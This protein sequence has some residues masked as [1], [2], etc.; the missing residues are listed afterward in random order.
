M[1]T[2]RAILHEAVDELEDGARLYAD[3]AERWRSFGHVLELGRC[4]L[5]AARCLLLNTLPA[6]A[7]EHLREAREML[8]GIDARPLIGEADL[9][10]ERATALTSFITGFRRLR[11]ELTA[12]P[13][14]GCP[15]VWQEWAR[16]ATA[17]AVRTLRGSPLVVPALREQ[18]DTGGIGDEGIPLWCRGLPPH[19]RARCGGLYIEPAAEPFVTRSN[20]GAIGG[21]REDHR[22]HEHA[23]Q[24]SRHPASGTA[25]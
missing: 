2:G 24:R 19:H 16:D 25:G 4:H 23:G 15:R 3:A 18:G 10:Q 11:T 22:G 20:H 1:I 12:V 5:G 21:G 14:G 8:A 17:A 13:F 6:E 7:T 9:L